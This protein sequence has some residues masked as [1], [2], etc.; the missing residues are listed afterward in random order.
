[1]PLRQDRS[2][3]SAPDAL[4]ASEELAQTGRRLGA[5]DVLDVAARAVRD[6]IA[7]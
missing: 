4:A 5:I 3:R 2:A 1:M 6:T 7:T